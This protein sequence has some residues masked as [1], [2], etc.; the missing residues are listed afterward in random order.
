MKRQKHFHTCYLCT[1]IE[2]YPQNLL[3]VNTQRVLVKMIKLFSNQGCFSS[4]Q[5]IFTPKYFCLQILTCHVLI[6]LFTYL[7]LAVL[8]L[9][10]CVSFSLV[11]ASGGHPPRA[12]L[13]SGLRTVEQGLQTRW[14]QQLWPWAQLLCSTWNPLDQ[15]WNPR[16]QLAGGLFTTESPGK[17]LNVLYFLLVLPS[18]TEYV[19][20]CITAKKATST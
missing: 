10:C 16:L 5:C 14:V 2:T 3:N 12:S 4:Y 7:F 13:C 20:Q 18:T 8:G 19:Q 9:H 17:P 1:F 15:G 6:V 11:E